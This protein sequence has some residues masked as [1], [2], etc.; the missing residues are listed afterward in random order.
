MTE[1]PETRP[2]NPA[3]VLLPCCSPYCWALGRPSGMVC[4]P[5]RS[6]PDKVSFSF[7]SGYQL[8]VWEWGLC[9]LALSALRPSH[10]ASLCEFIRASVLSCF[11]GAIHPFWL[12]QS[13]HL[14][15]CRVLSPE[16][17]ALMKTAHV[18]LLSAHCPA[19][20]LCICSHLVQGEAS[21]LMSEQ[22]TDL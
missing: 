9:S 11:L 3:T 4:I 10:A 21:L 6:P 8:K 2:S 16:G 22:D 1:H 19:V 13:F 7:G 17:K 14:L 15:L 5:S 18:G 12:P 20:V